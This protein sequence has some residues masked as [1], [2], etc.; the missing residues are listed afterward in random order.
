MADQRR[1]YQITLQ[2]PVIIS[3]TNKTTGEHRTLDRIPGRAL[4]GV[5]AR[6]YAQLGDDAWT[7]F[8]S[9]AVRFLDATP[10]VD[11]QRRAIATPRCLQKIKRT[12][13]DR[14]FNAAIRDNQEMD[15]S[16]QYTSLGAPYI[17]IDGDQLRLLSVDKTSVVKTAVESSGGPTAKEGHL[18]SYQAIA[19][20]QT[21]V[22][23]LEADDDVDDAIIDA[24][25]DAL[26][27]R[28]QLGRSRSAEFGAA[29]IEPIDAI[30]EIPSLATAGDT[31]LSLVLTS[32]LALVDEATG[33]PRLTPE[34][35][36]FGLPEHWQLDLDTSFIRHR[37]YDRFNGYRKSFDLKR[38][39]LQRGSVISF[40]SSNGSSLTD[41]ELA[42]I[43][44]V[45]KR[46]AGVDRQEGLGR[47]LL[48]PAWIQQQTLPLGSSTGE[49]SP[50]SKV[51]APDPALS[52]FVASRKAQLTDDKREEIYREAKHL[53]DHCA[54]HP[55]APSR[56]QWSRLRRWARVAD[57]TTENFKELA[58]DTNSNWSKGW[59]TDY[60][61]KPLA[62][63]LVKFGENNGA[64]MLSELAH[65][66]RANLVHQSAGH[67][68][69]EEASL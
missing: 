42:A 30:E 66:V 43:E 34:P 26:T 25:D 10:L 1:W 6:I 68:S 52:A 4:L 61:G 60:R 11:G 33:A 8:H 24:L 55:D 41:D 59:E 17:D 31:H 39:V 2:E 14:A 63:Y 7:A 3:A 32:E 38:H 47:Y 50:S 46:G 67:P 56:S 16:L 44:A 9:G 65:F 57:I 27:G 53:G 28:C 35:A 15:D 48:E 51:E 37:H 22:T 62:E 23:C 5:A 29:T 58:G 64:I 36:D 54:N 18:F 12:T 69:H 19:R 45:Q 13:P 21:F 49:D 40:Q 20:G